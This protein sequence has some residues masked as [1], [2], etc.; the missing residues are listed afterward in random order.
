MNS[1]NKMMESRR[2][3][4]RSTSLI[5][6]GT[7]AFAVMPNFAWAQDNPT[8]EGLAQVCYAMYPH[9]HVPPKYY[10]ACAQ[11]L[12]DK[13]A[14]DAALT[15]VLNDGMTTLDAV[16]SEPFQNLSD[17]DQQLALQRVVDSPFFQTVRGHT[18]VGLYNIPGVWE[19]FGYQGPSFPHGGY[20]D[21]GF[22]DIFW[23]KDVQ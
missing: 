20:L 7:T 22:D 1:D 13:A 16:Y 6:T 4:L 5:L 23:L 15:G 18:V 3:F 8:L 19:Y 11:G 12:L 2:D 17:D 9:R 10:K 21:R 14:G